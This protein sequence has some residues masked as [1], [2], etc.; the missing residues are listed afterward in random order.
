MPN[1]CKHGDQALYPIKKQCLLVH[2]I[3][4]RGPRFTVTQYH[5]TVSEKVPVGHAVST[6][7]AVVEPFSTPASTNF[8]TNISLPDVYPVVYSLV[9]TSPLRTQSQILRQNVPG[10]LRDPNLDK[11]ML[12][13]PYLGYHQLALLAAPFQVD[14]DTGTSFSFI[15]APL[16]GLTNVSYTTIPFSFIIL[17][18][19]CFHNLVRGQGDLVEFPW[20][21][22][23]CH[24]I[25][26]F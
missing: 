2:I 9:T 25:R 10:L 19:S 17:V 18:R 11:S 6:V 5:S 20:S 21:Y 22:V 8:Y 4:R 12:V 26:D 13:S 1:I 14:F 24:T 15:H 23:F 3:T 7:T 16:L